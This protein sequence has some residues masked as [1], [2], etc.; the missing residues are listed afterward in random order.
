MSGPV[1]TEGNVTAL[2][3]ALADK[4]H[5]AANSGDAAR[6]DYFD[7][8]LHAQAI[9]ATMWRSAIKNHEGKDAGAD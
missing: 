3:Q 9:V 2:M 6:Y 5:S 1:L 8:L 4:G 7:G